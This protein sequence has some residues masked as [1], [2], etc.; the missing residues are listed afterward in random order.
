MLWELLT[1]APPRTSANGTAPSLVGRVVA[2]EGLD[3]VLAMATDPAG[4]YATVAELLLGWRAAVGRPEGVL[5]PVTSSDR[6]AVDSMRR[7]AAHQL[8]LATAAG[9]NPYKGLRPFDEADAAAFYGRE[10]VVDA[11]VEAVSAHRLVT[12]VGASGSGKSSVVRAG[13][14]PRLRDAGHTV[15][16]MVPGD[17]PVAALRQALSEVSSRRGRAPELTVLIG[18]VVAACGPLVVVIDQLEECWTR[19]TDERRGDFID[20]IARLADGGPDVRFVATIRA[21]VFDRPLQD[22]RLGMHIGSSVFVLASMSPAQ[23]GDAITL[24]AVRAGVT[25]DE[26]VVADL[27]TEAAAQPGSLP[28]L[29]FTLA[30]LYDRRLDGRIG[31]DALMAIGG[32]AGSI[33]RRA[34]EVYLSLDEQAQADTQA[35]F[36][37]LVTPG[38]GIPDTRR[39]AGLSELSDGARMVADRYVAARLLVSDRD[40]ATREPTVEVA[41]EALLSRWARL[42]GWI[43]ADRRWLL[44]LQHLAAAATAWNERDRPEADLYRGARLETAIEAL[45]ADGR[46]VTDLERE[47]VDAGRDARDSELHAARRTARRLRRSL[48]GVGA[49]LVVALVAGGLAFVAQRRA[50]REEREA[51]HRALVSNSTALRGN[52]RELAALLAVEAH[53]LAPSAATESALFGTFTGTMG[54][55]A[56]VPS[57]RGTGS[58]MVDNETIAVSETSGTVHIVD[59]VQR[60]RGLQ[61][62]PPRRR[63]RRRRRQLGAVPRGDA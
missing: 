16:T 49:L 57:G 58:I 36:S 11:L 8:V 44:Q 6:R 13:L 46:A 3:A 2:P 55:I 37:R 33:G 31:P 9:V 41:H 62:H 30:E 15:V 32:M 48:V 4:G 34:E 12:V 1:G 60:C 50:N 40:Q 18:H 22:P 38:D 56:T 26:A 27:V 28:L 63:C 59:V 42:A 47:F 53:R 29:Q 14:I 45:D 61:P 52:K 5:S 35:L 17:D 21:D 24:P 43:D 51:D 25:V 20:V 54:L 10:A 7:S 39:R 23:L 19:S